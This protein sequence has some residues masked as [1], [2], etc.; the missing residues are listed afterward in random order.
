[1]AEASVAP[2]TWPCAF[3]LAVATKFVSRLLSLLPTEP[4]ASKAFLI[5]KIADSCRACYRL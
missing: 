5:L 4:A 2:E 1:M 3:H